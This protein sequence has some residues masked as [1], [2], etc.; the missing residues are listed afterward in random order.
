MKGII[1]AGGKATRLRPL[2]LVTSKQLLPVYNQ[3]M[4]Y[5]PLQ[6]LLK[7]GIK[8][9]LIIIAPDYAGHFLHLLGSGKEFGAKFTYEIQE[10]P[11]GLA[12]A[13]IIG[14]DFIDDD[15]V[16]M[17]L[18]D[19]IFSDDLSEEINTFQSGGRV[20]AIK[21]PDP[22]RYGVVKFDQGNKAE[23][24]VEKPKEKIGDHAVTGLYVYDKRVCGFA[25]ELR[26]SERGEIEITDINNKYLELGEL[27]VRKVP[28]KWFDAGTFDSLL[29]AS[30]FIAEREKGKTKR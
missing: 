12:D 18:G 25:K 15:D 22:E 14:K 30:N 6:T 9:I 27:D 4:I 26:P 7:A 20:F 24:I 1:L 23:L 3:P 28:G 29:E 8:E 19:N 21:V 11:K 17:I 13:F 2:T 5:Y 16:A 10:Q